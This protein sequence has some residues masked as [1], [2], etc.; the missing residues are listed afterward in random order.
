MLLNYI[1]WLELSPHIADPAQDL[2][3]CSS[4]F[5]YKDAIMVWQVK[6]HHASHYVTN[7]DCHSYFD[8]L[9]IYYYCGYDFG[10]VKAEIAALY[11]YQARALQRI[12]EKIICIPQW[13]SVN[14]QS[15]KYYICLKK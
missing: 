14:P 12:V 7:E 6:R 11:Y 9:D 10:A 2:E 13:A 3:S 1:T 4:C 5:V 15:M 8:N